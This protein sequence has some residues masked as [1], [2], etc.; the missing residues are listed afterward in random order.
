M[1]PEQQLLWVKEESTYDVAQ[2]ERNGASLANLVSL[3]VNDKPAVS[4]TSQSGRLRVK[5]LFVGIAA[6]DSVTLY[7]IPKFSPEPSLCGPQQCVEI[8]STALRAIDLATDHHVETLNAT[9]PSILERPPRWLASAQILLEDYVKHGIYSS[10]QEVIRDGAE[11]DIDWVETIE[12]SPVTLQKGR[13]IYTTMYV[14]DQRLNLETEVSRIHRAVLVNILGRL[15]HCDPLNALGL[16]RPN[17]HSEHDLSALGP[18]PRLSA[19]LS[20]ELNSQFEDR[21]IRLLQTLIRYLQYEADGS[22]HTA[23]TFIGTASFHIVWELACA[24]FFQDQFA[25]RGLRTRAPVW[26]YVTDYAPGGL[27]NISGGGTLLPDVVTTEAGGVYVLDAKYYTPDFL[28]E[29]LSHQPGVQDL[30]KQYLYV[31]AIQEHFPGK[32][33]LGNG[34]VLPARDIGS[35]LFRRRGTVEFPFL[36]DDSTSPP[37]GVFEI[38]PLALLGNFNRRSTANGFSLSQAFELRPSESVQIVTGG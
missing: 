17:L 33:V 25:T 35:G 2:L 8:M 24:W 21:R 15:Q 38:D 26:S 31:V 22:T 27:V 37:I 34:L 23:R 20:A 14:N 13:P 30:T 28:P 32:A 6:F 19:I 9:E 3:S 16:P 11:G 18:V 10:R 1:A 36:A 4:V 5:I 7:S 12:R 29:T